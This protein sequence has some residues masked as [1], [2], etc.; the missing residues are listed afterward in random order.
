MK[1][2]KS[3][4]IWLIVSSFNIGVGIGLTFLFFHSSTNFP[5]FGCG[6][7]LLIASIDLI[8]SKKLNYKLDIMVYNSEDAKFMLLNDILIG[9]I[10]SVPLTMFFT[11]LL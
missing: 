6:L 2:L 4:F 1:V 8:I 7:A 5:F 10:F 11:V 9:C 3:I